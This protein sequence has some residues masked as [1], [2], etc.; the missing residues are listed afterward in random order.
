MKSIAYRTGAMLLSMLMIVSMIAGCVTSEVLAKSGLTVTYVFT[1]DEADKAGFAQGDITITPSSDAATNGYYLIYYADNNDTLKGYDELATVKITGNTV[2]HSVKNGTMIPEE[3]TRIAVFENNTRILD[4]TPSIA[5]AAAVVEIPASKRLTL[6]EPE[7]SF[8]AA[9]DVHM[10]YQS[11]SRGAYEKWEAAMAFF[12][13]EQMDYVIVTGDMTGDTDLDT[14]YGKFVEI[15]EQSGFDPDKVYEAIGNHGNT[16]DN[17]KLFARYLF[18]EGE[19]HPFENS[20]YYSVLIEGKTET[21]RDNLFIF[22]QQE[23]EGPSDSAAYDN[24]SAEQIDWLASLLETYSGTETNIFV[25]EHSPFLDFGAGDRVGG[26]YRARVT[27]KEE[28]KQNMRLKA[29]LETYKDAIVMSGHTHVSLYDTENYSDEYNSF[30]RTVHV[31]STCFPCGYGEGYTYTRGYDGRYTA[32]ETYGSEAYLVDVY[33]DYIVYTGYNLST[34][35]IIPGACL[36]L[37]VKAYG[38]PGKPEPEPIPTPDE[39]FDGTGTLDDP[40]IIADAEDFKILTD[41]FNASTTTT[42]TEMYGY[43]K[44]FLQTADINMIGVEGYAGTTANGDAKCHFAGIYNGGGHTLTVDIVASNQ[45]SVFPYL[46]GTIANLHIKGR[47]H[48]DV[49]AQPIRTS[50]GNIVNCIFGLDLSADRAHGLLYSNY[51]YTYNVYTHGSL[52][53][54]YPD[55][56]AASDS[57]TN[58]VNAYHYYTLTDGEAVSDAQGTRSNDVAVI[59]EVFNNRMGEAYKTALATL[60]GMTMEEVAVSEG[61]LVFARSI[62]A[63]LGDVDG[64]GAITSGDVRMVLKDLLSDTSALTD[65]QRRAADMDANDIINTIDVRL[66]LRRLVAE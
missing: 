40:Y 10:D 51:K 33:A 23:L 65:K 26:G 34:G 47:I 36:L 29:L 58:N 62:A 5:D 3:A 2:T 1:G 35:K 24:F 59:A 12:K 55:A 54:T 15:I 8:G 52:A 64:D 7:M 44:Y 18:G 11:Y 57:S 14:Q 6:G 13:A 48:A 30:A 56:Y 50:R 46:Y 20:P 31:G 27:F 61:E 38:G 19:N 37:P 32:S 43:G 4:D 16:T 63:V 49:S 39:A 53:G 17:L 22:M 42:E 66:M 41:G 45:R 25:I 28:F 21:A 9:S 60:G